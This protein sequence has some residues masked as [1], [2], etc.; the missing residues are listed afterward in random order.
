M[1]RGRMWLR[2]AAVAAVLG[3]AAAG[4]WAA[5]NWTDV[6]V[7]YAAHRLKAAASEEERAAWADAL[8]ARGD[9]GLPA[10][11]ELV[12]TGEPPV[13]TAA[14]AALDRHLAAIPDGD[15]RAAALCG[16]LLDASSNCDDAGRAALLDLLPAILKRGGATSAPRCRDLVAGGLKSPAVSARLVAV[17]AG[18]HPNLRMQAELLPLLSAPE[19]EVRRAVLIAVGPAADGEPVVGD[20]ELFRWL[21]DPDAGVRAVCRDA[22]VSRGRTDAEIALGRRL[23]HPD[24]GERLKL[25]LDLRYDDDLAD[26]EPWLERLGRDPDPGVRAGAARVVAELCAERRL[27]APAWL[28]HIA[29]ADPDPTVRRVA[30]YFRA[31]DAAVRPAGGP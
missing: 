4:T 26:P 10:L 23:V 3:L 7:R 6:T 19:P 15:P 9:A 30:R 12:R 14:V 8:A 11:V 20:E 31:A 29:E 13:R 1:A 21:H 28:G 27:P 18:M 16:Q 25:L 24:A 2:R 17:R 5:F 22:L